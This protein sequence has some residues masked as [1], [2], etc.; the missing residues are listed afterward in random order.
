MNEEM[1]GALDHFCKRRGYSG[2][3]CRSAYDEVNQ[4]TLQVC[5]GFEK[6]EPYLSARRLP[7]ILNLYE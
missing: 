7:T 1:N 3:G 6:I 2:P 5:P 4:M